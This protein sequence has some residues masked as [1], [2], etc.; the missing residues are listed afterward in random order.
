MVFVGAGAGA[1][2]RYWIG[3]LW[4][5]HAYAGTLVVN[6]LGSF[7]MGIGAAYWLGGPQDHHEKLLL[8][9]G[10]LGGFTTFSSFSNEV[11]QQLL[12]GRIGEAVGYVVFANLASIGTCAMSFFVAQRWLAR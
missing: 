6:I 11:V 2:A 5:T 12:K 10:F 8:G 1:V 3:L 4:P 9:V 7:L